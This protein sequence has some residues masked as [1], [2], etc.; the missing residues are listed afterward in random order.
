MRG[1]PETAPGPQGA[2]GGD[3]KIRVHDAAP[4]RLGPRH[5][6]TQSTQPQPQPP[7]TAAAAARRQPAGE[8]GRA[9]S[10]ALLEGGAGLGAVEAVLAA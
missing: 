2:P 7:P 4:A 6:I 10:L 9:G 1:R 8:A 3:T 5:Q